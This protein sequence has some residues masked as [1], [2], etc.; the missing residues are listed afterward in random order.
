MS[1]TQAARFAEE[2]RVIEQYTDAVSGLS[3]TVFAPVNDP[4]ARYLAFRGTEPAANDL[5]ADGLLALGLPAS[6]NPQYVALKARI[7]RW[8]ADPAMLG[9]RGFSVAGHSDWAV[10]RR[11]WR[12][13]MVAGSYFNCHIA[14]ACLCQYPDGMHVR[15][16]E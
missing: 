7:D 1:P 10:E 15:D 16:G 12:D 6:L 3:V 5:T 9:G 11:T 4:D 14:A 13:G 2:W 8:L